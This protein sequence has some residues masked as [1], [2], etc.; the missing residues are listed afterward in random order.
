M[1][2]GGLFDDQTQVATAM[3]AISVRSPPLAREKLIRFDTCPPLQ[4]V[5][6]PVAAR[7]VS[8]TR[9][10]PDRDRQSVAGELARGVW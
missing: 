3:G 10:M 1:M 7:P 2:L 8:R 6:A 9:W 4:A 5:G